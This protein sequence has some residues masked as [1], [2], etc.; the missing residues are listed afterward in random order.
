M[1]EKD[2][3]RTGNAHGQ[4]NIGLFQGRCIVGSITSDSHYLSLLAQH[5]HE[6]VLVCWGGACKYLHPEKSVGL[7][8]TTMRY[9]EA[10]ADIK[11]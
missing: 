5:A 2:E 4:T 10:A 1:R 11:H 6:R 7:D 9:Q 8:T 3:W